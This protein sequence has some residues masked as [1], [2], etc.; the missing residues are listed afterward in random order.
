MTF[1]G[2]NA[3]RGNATAEI[4][5]NINRMGVQK[6]QLL[7]MSTIFLGGWKDEIRV[8]VLEN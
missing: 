6:V 5:N 4:A 3:E 8:K 1:T 7:M 2:T